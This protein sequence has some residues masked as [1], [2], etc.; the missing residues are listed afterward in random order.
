MVNPFT[1]LTANITSYE[2]LSRLVL[3]PVTKNFVQCLGARRTA[4]QRGAS[5]L[6]YT[7]K[8]VKSTLAELGGAEMLAAQQ[9]VVLA[10][11]DAGDGDGSERELSSRC[12]CHS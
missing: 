12:A 7:S 11:V 10:E 5:R 8:D 4:N 1:Y 2:N 6:L 9:A 3:P